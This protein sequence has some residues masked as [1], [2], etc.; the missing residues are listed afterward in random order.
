MEIYNKREMNQG[1]AKNGARTAPARLLAAGLLA[2]V[3]FLAVRGSAVSVLAGTGKSGSSTK[4]IRT[5][6]DD[7]F[8][9]EV[10]KL[11]QKSRGLAA[12]SNGKVRTYSSGRLIVRVLDGKSIDFSKYNAST[13]IQSDFGVCVVQF[14]SET[15]ARKAAKSLTAL[16][17][18]AYAEADDCTMSTGD[19]E[20][21]EITSDAGIPSVS[22]TSLGGSAPA[23]QEI[24]S[25]NGSEIN[26][27]EAGKLEIGGRTYGSDEDVFFESSVKTYTAS[28]GSACMS[29][30]VSYI[31]ADKYAAF[32]K[33]NTSQTIKVAVVD[34]GVS[35]HSKLSSRILKGKDYV[36]NDNDPSD[37][38]GHGTHVAGTIVDCTPGLNVKILPVR[39]MNASGVGNPS[40]VGN[41]I[42]YA[43]NQGAKVINLSLG[44]YSHYKYIEDCIDYAQKK[45]VTVVVAAG[46]ECENTR[47]ICP[48][49]M[50]SPIVV[51]AINRNGKRAFFSNYGTSLD[52]VAP[53]VD[54]KSCW[55]NGKYATATGTSMAAPHISAA[56][57][58]YRLMYPSATASKIQYY[59]RCYAKDL[60]Q[61]GTDS[62]YGRGV[63]RMAGAIAPSKVGL[64]K[65]SV[66]LPLKKTLTLKATIT[67][68][69]AG[70]K[71]LTWTSSNSTIVSVSG[72]KLTAKKKGTATITVRTVNGKKAV[73]KV[74]VTKPVVSSASSTVSIMR[75][76]I[77][78]DFLPSS[79]APKAVKTVSTAA[80]S[81]V[82][83]K[84]MGST[85]DASAVN[86]SDESAKAQKSS[87]SG[88]VIA[89]AKEE[90]V[91]EDKKD[92]YVEK[93]EIP[94]EEAGDFLDENGIS[95]D[96]SD[97]SAEEAASSSDPDLE[98][99]KI[100][101]Y[102]SEAPGN[103]PVQDSSIVAGS[104]LA[105]E[106][107]IVPALQH[108]FDLV[109]SSS[110]PS[111]AEVDENGVLTALSQGQTTIRAAL[112]ASDSAVGSFTISVVEPSIL[113][114]HAS[115]DGG[116][117]NTLGIEAVLRLPGAIDGTTAG[118]SLDFAVSDS[119][120]SAS[121]D[122]YPSY[123]L[124]LLLEDGDDALLVGAV[125]LGGENSGGIHIHDAE[126][127]ALKTGVRT[128]ADAAGVTGT[129][130]LFEDPSLVAE[131]ILSGLADGEKADQAGVLAVETV[132]ADGGKADL[133]LTADIGI[134]R[135]LAENTGNIYGYP[136]DND[137]SENVAQALWKCRLA[138]YTAEVFEERERAVKD[139]DADALCRADKDTLCTCR[140]TLAFEKAENHQS[141]DANDIAPAADVQETSPVSSEKSTAETEEEN[142]SAI[143]EDKDAD[144]G[145]NAVDGAEAGENAEAVGG[146]E[147]EEEEDAEA[148]GKAEAEE[149][150]EAVDKAEAED[151]ANA[152][153]RTDVE[154]DAE[155]DVAADAEKKAGAAEAGDD[156][157]A[158]KMV[159]GAS[160]E[161]GKDVADETDHGAVK[162]GTDPAGSAGNNA[163]AKDGNRTGSNEDR[164]AAPDNGEAASESI[165]IM[166][167][168]DEPA[169]S[170]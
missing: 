58:M 53:G 135:I 12:Q 87:S 161:E 73:C 153:D 93:T 122:P 32:V 39:V 144:D 44:G 163:E 138:V 65:S 108:P 49:H 57:A 124:A 43:V 70:R 48:A 16:S 162:G 95:A 167:G 82:S 157:D 62:Y 160:G 66:S 71:K 123:V 60:G 10:S 102:P 22:A 23:E 151:G 81:N 37:K 129:E 33:A 5:S 51:G 9:K 2:A 30:G 77:A 145:A 80:A 107:E 166:G 72:G 125:D 56:A 41:G 38:N 140:F 121:A 20:I 86:K 156:A 36:D 170:E 52:I 85:A 61:S 67:P 42:R 84:T 24:P 40:T 131:K 169:A 28:T 115:Y 158:T 110:D 45:N 14:P 134:L 103:A 136:G 27:G 68:S 91:S 139:R 55:L 75:Q 164:N 18:V 90:A 50:S 130:A 25:E 88:Q 143:P 97:V 132:K 64:S 83:S 149:D 4:V 69:Y 8:A 98:A 127:G 168:T 141:E 114:R 47:Y 34:S 165:T 79:K 13:V 116:L 6:S 117:G 21:K 113:T 155:R 111:V 63:P 126:S 31:Q 152:A 3:L 142:D 26:V 35:K 150:A 29:W 94:V 78:S 105:L 19:M 15:S 147:E 109:W 148:V 104:V 146:A 96:P 76:T 112:S 17:S 101:V 118:A 128:V 99:V 154:D 133:S 46:N 1:E 137:F 159:G 120:E 54:I 100:Y 106:V 11:A 92:A 7:E 74:T 89:S 119:A 59:I